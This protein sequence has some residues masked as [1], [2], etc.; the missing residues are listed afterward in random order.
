MEMP[1]SLLASSTKLELFIS[2]NYMSII[3][4]GC[5]LGKKIAEETLEVSPLLEDAGDFRVSIW[6]S[7]NSCYF[8]RQG[9]ILVLRGLV[10]IT[11]FSC[12]LLPS[13]SPKCIR[14]PG[15]MLKS[16]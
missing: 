9:I 5:A 14:R 2:F 16:Y 8:L 12:P 10:L 11:C 7:F 6:E 15:N 4:T 3:Y 13:P 1:P